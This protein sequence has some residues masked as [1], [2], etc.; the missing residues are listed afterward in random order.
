MREGKRERKGKTHRPTSPTGL[1]SA[2]CRSSTGRAGR[3][4][5]CSGYSMSPLWPVSSSLISPSRKP[6]ALCRVRRGQVEE[7]DKVAGNNL[8]IKTMSVYVR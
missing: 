8:R 6:V 4:H 7:S 5:C 3:M 2:R 1:S